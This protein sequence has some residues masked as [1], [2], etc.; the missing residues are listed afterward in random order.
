MWFNGRWDALPRRDDAK[1]CYDAFIK[2]MNR[3]AED[4]GLAQQRKAIDT[5]DKSIHHFTMGLQPPT[6]GLSTKPDFSVVGVSK[7]MSPFQDM[8]V[9]E[10]N[11]TYRNIRSVI[12]LKNNQEVR[13]R[14][15][16]YDVGIQLACY[17]REQLYEQPNRLFVDSLAVSYQYMRLFCFDRAG[18][19]FF[20]CV[21]IHAYPVLFVQA[22][23]LMFVDDAAI[24]LD[25][26]VEYDSD[27]SPQVSA[28]VTGTLDISH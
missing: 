2:I 24:G 25:E 14:D 18:P 20:D 17:A 19:S 10:S 3:I 7:S 16:S 22:I 11:V 23:L 26:S 21:D 5:K 4:F 12:D 8:G 13:S 6:G 9:V 27:S 1:T 28:T 15:S